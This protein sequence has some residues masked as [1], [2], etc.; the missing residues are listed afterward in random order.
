MHARP[1]L[2]GSSGSHTVRKVATFALNERFAMERIDAR[3][4]TCVVMPARD[5]AAHLRPTLEALAGQVDG[6]GEP[7]ER[8]CFEVILLLN[9]CVDDSPAVARRAAYELRDRLRLHIVECELPTATAHVGMARRLL[10]DTAWRRL[11]GR[12]RGAILS[13][14][15]DTVVARDWIAANLRALQRADIVGGEIR[16]AQGEMERLPAGVRQA[17][18]RDSQLQELVTEIEERLD[19]LPEDPLP[20]HRHE[21]GASLGCTVEIYAR[22]G[23]LPARRSLEDIAFVARARRCGARV[24][25]EPMVQVYTS[26]RLDGKVKVGL[27]GQLRAWDAMSRDGRDHLV[28]SADWI[29]FRARLAGMLRRYALT[30]SVEDLRRLPRAWRGKVEAR[31]AKG[32]APTALVEAYAKKIAGAYAGER[33]GEIGTVLRRLEGMLAE[34]RDASAEAPVDEET[35]ALR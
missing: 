34:L 22:T 7:M 24:R 17:Y 21:F 5:E 6:R 18:E 25:H 19:P 13:T 28:P 15:S 30:G 23:G 31:V 12:R 14:D 10:M 2:Q 16:W 1:R 29:V 11:E 33:K 32:M 20:R 26:G 35:M 8:S 27:S 4:G 3:C 9:N